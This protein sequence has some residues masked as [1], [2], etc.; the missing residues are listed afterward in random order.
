MCNRSSDLD[1]SFLGELTAGYSG[2]DL[3][4]LVNAALFQP[5]R[6]LKNTTRWRHIG[7]GKYEY[8][9]VFLLNFS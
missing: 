3:A 6:E 8:A 5:V 7:D 1:S 4:T 2:S 9:A